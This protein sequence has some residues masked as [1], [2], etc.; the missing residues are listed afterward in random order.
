VL[1]DS[2]G[3]FFFLF[4]PRVNIESSF[5]KI[6]F[7]IFFLS[8]SSLNIKLRILKWAFINIHNE[9]TADQTRSSTITSME[10]K[11]RV[12]GRDKEGK[13]PNCKDDRT[14][15]ARVPSHLWR[16][17]GWHASFRSAARSVGTMPPMI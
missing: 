9:D 14:P 5:K 12:L 16:H 17:A 8:I 10:T 3:R 2:W 7:I 15:F 11:T 1:R 13:E 4:F 6:L